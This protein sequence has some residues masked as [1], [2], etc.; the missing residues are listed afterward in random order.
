MKNRIFIPLIA[1]SLFCFNQANSQEFQY[2]SIPQGEQTNA[3]VSNSE[4]FLQDQQAEEGGAKKLFIGISGAYNLKSF[5]SSAASSNKAWSKIKGASI[6]PALDITYMITPKIGI[7]TGIKLG[8]YKPGYKIEGFTD[9]LSTLYVD[10]DREDYY[11]V[12][13]DMNLE[14]ITTINSL[15][16]PLFARYKINKGKL[17]Y[18]ADLGLIFT[19]VTDMSYTLSGTATRKGYYPD[20]EVVLFGLPEYN[21]TDKTYDANETHELET[22]GLGLSGFLSIGVLYE[23]HSNILVK[24]GIAG[25]YGLNDFGPEIPSTY[26]KFYSSTYLGKVSLSSLSF[27]VGIAY[28]LK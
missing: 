26:N 28:T 7:G 18:Y 23:V 11:P 9:Q 16:I 8:S 4:S 13:E 24:V 22:P 1:F 20:L 10:I 5:S 14:E 17:N 27:E 3:T 12:Y 21:F 6:I 2:R 15:D 19:S 25:S